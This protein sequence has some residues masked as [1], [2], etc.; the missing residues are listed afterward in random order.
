MGEEEKPQKIINLLNR[1]NIASLIADGVALFWKR[2]LL[3]EKVPLFYSRPWGE[4]QLAGR[5][6]L[7]SIPALSLLIFLINWQL[8][9]LLFKKKETFLPIVIESFALLFSVLGTITLLRI[10]FLIT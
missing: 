9:K 8:G 10:I 1:I 4:E 6:W 2:N 3:P 7:F 5:E